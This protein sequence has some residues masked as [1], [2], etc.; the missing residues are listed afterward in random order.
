MSR[1][2]GKWDGEQY[3]YETGADPG[4][5]KGFDLINFPNYSTYSDGQA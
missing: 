4:F 5:L 3:F 1:I 2:D